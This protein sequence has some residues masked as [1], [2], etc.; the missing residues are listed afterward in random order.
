M[1]KI[2]LISIFSLF[3]LFN[4]ASAQILCIYCYEQNDSISQNVN[5]MVL[6]GSFE[7]TT[8]APNVFSNSFCP[9]SN[10]YGCTVADWTCTGGGVDSYTSIDDSTFTQTADGANAAY[11]GNGVF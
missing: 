7:N 3:I 10:Y 8:C 9:L 5:N 4:F 6:N 11:F 2:I 1:K